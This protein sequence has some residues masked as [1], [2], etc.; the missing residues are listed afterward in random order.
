MRHY[1]YADI[2]SAL[3]A[4]IR[5]LDLSQFEPKMPEDV[6]ELLEYLRRSDASQNHSIANLIESL[7]AQLSEY[8]Q[9]SNQQWERAENWEADAKRYAENA[10]YWRERAEKAE[11]RLKDAHD[12]LAVAGDDVMRVDWLETKIVT[13]ATPLRYGSRQEFIANNIADEED[14]PRSEVRKAI[15]EA[16]KGGE[17]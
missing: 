10:D 16:L 12:Q 11:Q 13:V 6:Q 7:S 17:K 3:G 14:A 4:K 1:E 15:D 5:D 9:A 2:A 8:K